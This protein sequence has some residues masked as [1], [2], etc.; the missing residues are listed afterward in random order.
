MKHVLA[1]DA[2]TTGVTC[3]IIGADGKVAGRG[4]RRVPAFFPA[5]GPV[6]H[7][8]TEILA[9]GEEAGAEAARGS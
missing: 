3:L 8:A 2:G 4:H 9:P 5:N 1:I 7:G 6:Q